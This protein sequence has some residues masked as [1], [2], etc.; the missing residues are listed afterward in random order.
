MNKLKVISVDHDDPKWVFE[1]PDP[2][3]LGVPVLQMNEVAFG[4]KPG[5]TLFSG[6]NFALT[7]ESRVVLLGPN[8]AGQ[9]S[10]SVCVCR[11]GFAC[12]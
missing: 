6:V 5:S 8:G 7:A 9:R 10:H 3:Q 11:V 12:G 4:Y 1:F 2:G